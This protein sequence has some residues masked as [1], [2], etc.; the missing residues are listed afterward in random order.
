MHRLAQLPL[1]SNYPKRQQ[2]HISKKM[3]QFVLEMI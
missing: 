3:L 2:M 1:M